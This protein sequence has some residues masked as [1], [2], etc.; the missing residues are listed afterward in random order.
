MKKFAKVIAVVIAI[1]FIVS[2]FA[3]CSGGSK[4]DA[5]VKV[6]DINLTTENYAF[7]VDKAQPELLTAVNDF[8]AEIKE[9]G[10]FDEIC[11]KYFG[12]GTPT[13]VT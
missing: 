4:T 13:P 7:G 10:K 11:S 6:I 8:I 5:K 9:N 3:A 2:A 1:T 12:E